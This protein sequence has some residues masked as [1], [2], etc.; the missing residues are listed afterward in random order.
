MIDF[1]EKC[2]YFI[3][4]MQAKTLKQISSIKSGYAFRGAIV[5]NAVSGVRVIQPR[6]IITNNILDLVIRKTENC[7]CGCLLNPGDV[8]ITNRGTIR[9]MVFRE[10]FKAIATSAVFILRVSDVVLP[11]YLAVYINSEMGQHQIKMR[12]EL[13][14]VAALT[15]RQVAE[16]VVPIP[17]MDVQEKLVRLYELQ[18]RQKNLQNELIVLRDKIFNNTLK[19]VLNG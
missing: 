8:L 13:S 17:A 5:G 11:E 1:G 19:G 6:D 7:F 2:W 16:L 14:T 15:V 18:Q 9:A 3:S 10:K 4:V 12:Q